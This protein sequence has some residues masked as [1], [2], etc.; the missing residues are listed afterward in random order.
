MLTIFLDVRTTRQSLLCIR[1]IMQRIN[2][3]IS[4]ESLL[5]N[6]KTIKRMDKFCKKIW[7]FKKYNLEKF[8]TFSYFN[9]SLKQ[10][11]LTIS[12]YLNFLFFTSKNK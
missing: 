9:F 4:V 5:A 10:N 6:L 8:I 11:L 12:I 3:E 2:T 1:I 7:N